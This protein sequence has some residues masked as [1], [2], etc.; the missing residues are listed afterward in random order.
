MQFLIAPSELLLMLLPSIVVKM[1]EEEEGRR[2]E[3]NFE[4]Q[5]LFATASVQ[6]VSDPSNDCDSTC[7]LKLHLNIQQ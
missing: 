2:S 4:K 5:Q 3:N 7:K 1:K 6:T